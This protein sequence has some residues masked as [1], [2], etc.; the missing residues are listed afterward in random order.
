MP[1]N[2]LEHSHERAAED[3]VRGGEQRRGTEGPGRDV[4]RDEVLLLVETARFDGDG[5]TRHVGAPEPEPPSVSS[6]DR[7][8]T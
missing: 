3:L 8:M 7:M 5:A 1:A 4:F 2:G 6:R